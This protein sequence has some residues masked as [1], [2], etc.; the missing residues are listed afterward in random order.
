MHWKSRD[1]LSYLYHGDSLELMA[2]IP[3]DTIDC[4]WTD[5]PYFLSNDGITCVAGRMVKVNKGDWDRSNGL[6]NDHQFNRTWLAECLRILK[7][8]GTIW[9][10]G[11]IHV[12]FSVGMAMLEL[13]F[14]ILNDITWEKP[15]PP[16]NLGRRCFTHSTE[17][18]LWAT[19]A[20]KGSKHRHTFNYD[21][22][23]AE[24]GGRQMKTVWTMTPPGS[25]E[26]KYGKHPTQKPLA[27]IQRC[28][29][30]SS[31]TDDIIL[32]PFT[33]SGA[34]GVAALVLGR[35]FIGV[36]IQKEFAAIAR[37]RLIG[38]DDL[39][40]ENDLSYPLN[41]SRPQPRLIETGSSP[42]EV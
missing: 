18:L 7:P 29:R 13:G 26:K 23:R 15:N 19:K 32:D 33:G 24:N 25:D 40:K 11:T 12:Y 22:M 10:T 8:A 28:L 2:T 31:N 39:T 38:A 14:R 5:P 1:G 6:D 42:Y 16:P 3:N 4:I 9:V 20:K 37:S 30:A 36:E 41:S 35:R 27:L 34:T 21:D 17:T